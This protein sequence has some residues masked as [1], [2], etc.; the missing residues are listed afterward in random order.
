MMGLTLIYLLIDL[1]VHWILL[2]N[3]ALLSLH[4]FFALRIAV[5]ALPVGFPL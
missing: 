4:R 1:L 5:E 3:C 2:T